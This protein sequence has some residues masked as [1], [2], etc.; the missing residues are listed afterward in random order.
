VTGNVVELRRRL[1]RWR[2]GAVVAGALAAGLAAFMVIDR[3]ALAPAPQSGRYL[4]VVDAGGHEP[5]LIAAIDTNSGEIRIRSLAAEA[6]AGRSLELWHVPEGEAPR[7]LGLI[8][9]G[10]E[11]QTI[12]DAASGPLAGI[13]AVSVEPEGGS[14]SGAPTGPVIYSGRL[15][16]VE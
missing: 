14:P 15:I 4:A 11:A 8:E 13:L 7:S 3:V 10:T 16:P 9:P 1:V 2:A 6:P 12:R 5:A